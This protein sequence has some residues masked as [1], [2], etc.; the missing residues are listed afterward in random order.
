MKRLIVP[1]FLAIIVLVSGCIGSSTTPTTTTTPQ[2]QSTHTITKTKE[3]TRT[4]TETVTITMT[5]THYPLTIVDSLG[6]R[7]TIERTSKDSLS[8]PEHN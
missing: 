1:L 2:T 7:V 5:P 8:R 6:R 4:I 3:M